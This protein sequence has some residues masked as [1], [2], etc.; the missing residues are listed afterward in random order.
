LSFNITSVYL[1]WIPKKEENAIPRAA[2]KLLCCSVGYYSFFKKEK[3][4]HFCP[5]FT[6]QRRR[7][8]ATPLEEPVRV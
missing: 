2:R 4:R 7:E 8:E 3:A 6:N 1:P 5:A